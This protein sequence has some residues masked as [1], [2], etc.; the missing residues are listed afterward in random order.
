VRSAVLRIILDA[1]AEFLRRQL[2]LR[3]QPWQ[4][5]AGLKKLCFHYEAG[6]RLQNAADHRQLLRGLI[7]EPDLTIR[8]WAYKALGLIGNAND[9]DPL[10]ARLRVE[11]DRESQ[12]WAMASL[13][14]L[15]RGS[16]LKDL[17][18]R[19]DLELTA[20]LLLAA[21]LYAPKGWWADEPLP[22]I[23]IDRADPLT[24]RWATLLEGY[25]QAPP[26]MFEPKHQNRILL[27]DLNRHEI[28]DVAEYSIWALWQNPAYGFEDFGIPL[29]ALRACPG[30]V[31][32]WANR[33]IL[34]DPDPSAID[35]ALLTDLRRD[36]HP[37]AREGLAL[38][39]DSV[40]LRDM[41][42]F[43]LDWLSD[44]SAEEVEHTVLE[45]IAKQSDTSPDFAHIVF[46]RFRNEPFDSSLGQRL[47]VAT[48][49]LP[50]YRQLMRHKLLQS[51]GEQGILFGQTNVFISEMTMSKNTTTFSAGRDISGQNLVGG[52]MINSANAAVQAVP[53]Q[54]AHER[55]VLQRV[56]EVLG[57]NQSVKEGDRAAVI[58]AVQDA[59]V[60]PSAAAKG[61]LLE[62]LGSIA[63]SSSAAASA[64]GGVDK[65]IGAIR[66]LPFN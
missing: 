58:Q 27:R 2:S 34:K 51:A 56:L 14:R 7:W 20:P 48:Q 29:H 65:L 36:D 15:S 57:T 8:N 11:T 24:L 18:T 26:H 3:S 40:R 62:I 60:R 19:T 63:S 43:V 52:D 6:R 4:I 39:L 21:R 12:A 17:S 28:A 42:D 66:D 9:V 59:A 13:L 64:I 41:L 10:I 25:G 61:K 23:D 35:E 22:Q 32:R 50:I 55:E 44:E 46:E 33:L 1:E 54:R 31:R 16:N 49:G 30:N 47:I 45:Q 5:K 37:P 53:D 38:G